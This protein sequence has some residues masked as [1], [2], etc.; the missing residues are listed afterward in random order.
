MHGAEG[1][2]ECSER[3]P[4]QYRLIFLA[5]MIGTAIEIPATEKRSAQKQDLIRERFQAANSRCMAPP[6]P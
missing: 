1:D 6:M 4:E 2:K 3:K 5:L